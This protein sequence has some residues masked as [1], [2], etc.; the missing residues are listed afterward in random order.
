MAVGAQ[1]NHVVRS[2]L[3]LL[4]PRNKTVEIAGCHIPPTPSTRHIG[5][6]LF[7]ATA[8]IGEVPAFPGEIPVQLTLSA[9]FAVAILL[10]TM[11]RTPLITSVRRA[12]GPRWINYPYRSPTLNTVLAQ[13][14]Y[15][16]VAGITVEGGFQ[17]LGSS[18]CLSY[19]MCSSHTIS[20]SA[21]PTT[22]RGV[23]PPPLRRIG[24]MSSWNPTVYANHPVLT[25]F[26]LI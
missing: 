22:P 16:K 12:L 24:I 25:P 19:I 17:N 15:G 9:P 13:S 5:Y 11:C 8:L 21:Q 18:L 26:I 14:C 23:R 2:V 6:A 10:V 20:D 7:P 1:R 4:R 3:S